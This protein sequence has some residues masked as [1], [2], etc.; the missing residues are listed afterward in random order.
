[1]TVATFIEANA[2]TGKTYEL[3]SYI[4]Q[5]VMAGVHAEKYLRGNLHRKS[6]DRNG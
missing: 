2:G 1:M 4:L 3:T 5:K 6:R